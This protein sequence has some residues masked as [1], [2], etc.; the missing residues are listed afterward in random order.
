MKSKDLIAELQRLDPTG[1]TEVCVGNVDIYFASREGAYYDGALQVLKHD[2][3]LRGKQYSIIGA[4]YRQTGEKIQLHT[5]SIREMLIDVP[6]AP[7][8]FVWPEDPKYRTGIPRY[9]AMIDKWRVE[10]KER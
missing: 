9:Q 10:A 4:E 5:L 1:E 3:A 8:E 7:V 2:E 6:D